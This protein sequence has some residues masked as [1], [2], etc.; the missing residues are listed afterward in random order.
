[1]LVIVLLMVSVSVDES[2]TV[3]LPFKFTPPVKVSV[4]PTDKLPPMVAAPA[5]NKLRG[6]VAPDAPM[7]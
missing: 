6:R 1:M 2:P 4:P 7:S 5:R 3:T